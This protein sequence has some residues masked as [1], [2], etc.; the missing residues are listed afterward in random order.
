MGVR[1]TLAPREY[2]HI[3][4][5]GTDKRKIFLAKKD[6][7][8]FLALLY[9]SNGTEA[10]HISNYQG[11]TLMEL[12]ELERGE[13]LVDIGAYCLMLNHFHLLVR[14]REENGVSK[15]MQKLTTGYTM[16]FNKRNERT[17]A[18]FQGKF[19]S[20]HAGEDRYLKYLIAYLHLNPGTP[21]YPY[22]S[23]LDYMDRGRAEEKLL[24]KKCLPEYFPSPKDFLAEM[25]EW[26]SYRS[27]I[28]VEP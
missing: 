5:R 15:F 20:K 16:Y 14:Q 4:N 10:V 3:Y 13:P 27:N 2:Y 24:N 7:E 1:G 18:L 23:C 12:L 26:L 9:L 11:S 22:S 6:Y 25:K 28:K 19:K 8:R 21:N 17:G